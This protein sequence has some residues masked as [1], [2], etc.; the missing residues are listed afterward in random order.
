MVGVCGHVAVSHITQ[1]WNHL[2]SLTGDVWIDIWD[3]IVSEARLASPK[4]ARC[5]SL[6]K[7][8]TWTLVFDQKG[9]R[10][11]EKSALDSANCIVVLVSVLILPRVVGWAGWVCCVCCVEV[12]CEVCGHS[13]KGDSMNFR[14][15]GRGVNVPILPDSRRWCLSGQKGKEESN[16]SK[17]L[18]HEW[19]KEKIINQG[20]LLDLSLNF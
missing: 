9:S 2:Y 6:A 16:Q 17:A 1:V 20:P 14:I 19:V 3:A 12:S 15:V 18:E 7:I 8:V 13:W 4:L 5:I 10:P 11:T